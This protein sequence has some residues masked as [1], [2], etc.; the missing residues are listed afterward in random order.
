MVAGDVS[1][2]YIVHIAGVSV[3]YWSAVQ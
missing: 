2:C 1:V 3:V